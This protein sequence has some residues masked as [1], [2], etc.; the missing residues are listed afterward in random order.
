MKFLARGRKLWYQLG[1]RGARQEY[2]PRFLSLDNIAYWVDATLGGIG[3]APELYPII[4]KVG[5]HSPNPKPPARYPYGMIFT[6]PKLKLG[7]RNKY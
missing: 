2:L 3:Y 6:C 5:E 4:V 7:K 1:G